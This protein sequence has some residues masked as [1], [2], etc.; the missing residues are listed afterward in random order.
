MRRPE[1]C[2]GKNADIQE[3]VT[4]LSNPL[5]IEPSTEHGGG[6]EFADT[7]NVNG[8]DGGALPLDQSASSTARLRAGRRDRRGRGGSGVDM[9]SKAPRR[10]I[11]QSI[12]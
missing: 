2:S 7:Q 9:Q 3:D 1:G 8:M 11:N 10:S 5:L 12:H 4:P 6:R